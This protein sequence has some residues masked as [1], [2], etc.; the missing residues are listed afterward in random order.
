MMVLWLVKRYIELIS[1]HHASI[2]TMINVDHKVKDKLNQYL[3]GQYEKISFWMFLFTMCSRNNHVLTWWDNISTAA[4]YAKNDGSASFSEAVFFGCE[5]TH[6]RLIWNTTQYRDDKKNKNMRYTDKCW[7]TIAMP[8]N[9]FIIIDKDNNQQGQRKNQ[10]KG[11]SNQ[12]MVVTHSIAIKP[13]K[14]PPRFTIADWYH[15]TKPLI[16]YL[17]QSIIGALHSNSTH[18]GLYNKARC[19]KKEVTWWLWR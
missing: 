14:F 5:T 19:T 12:F 18:T 4:R 16:T 7:N 11:T 1:I 10:W 15:N 2:L 9:R 13:L 6:N 3:L 17:K 8:D